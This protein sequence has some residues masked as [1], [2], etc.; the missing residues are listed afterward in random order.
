MKLTEIENEKKVIPI[1][2]LRPG[3]TVYVKSRGTI[4]HCLQ[5]GSYLQLGGM[6]DISNIDRPVGTTETGEPI[7]IVEILFRKVDIRD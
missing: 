4:L 6:F 3:Q 2:G 5:S 7:E 1:V